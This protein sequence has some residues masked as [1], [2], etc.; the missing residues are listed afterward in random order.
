MTTN[1]QADSPT[2]H[3]KRKRRRFRVRA[4]D[5]RTR[6]VMGMIVVIAVVISPFYAM[7][8]SID[9]ESFA[10]YIAPVATVAGIIM[11]WWF[12]GSTEANDT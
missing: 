8:R 12:R 1:A 11:G 5:E 4:F 6:A 9:P 7:E 2:H 3:D 10:T